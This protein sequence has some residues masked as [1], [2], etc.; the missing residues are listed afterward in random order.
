VLTTALNVSRREASLQ[1]RRTTSLCAKKG[2]AGAARSV[3]SVGMRVMT[4]VI[5]MQCYHVVESRSAHRKTSNILLANRR[6][7]PETSGKQYHN[8]A[9]AVQCL[10]TGRDGFGGLIIQV[11]EIN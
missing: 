2:V 6:W 11:L 9:T 8:L 3:R 7:P 1:R 10:A 4:S 5:I